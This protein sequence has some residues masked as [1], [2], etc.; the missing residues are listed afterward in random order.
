MASSILVITGHP[1][2]GTSFTASLL[3]SAGLHIGQ[4]L[5]AP[6]HGN[7]KGFFEDLD[8][9]GFHEAVLRSQGIHHVGWTVEENIPVDATFINK[10]QELVSNNAAFPIWG[11]KDPRTTLFLDFWEQLLPEANFL[12]LYRAPWEVADSIYRRGDEL[13]EEEPDLA[14][15][16]WIHYN[17]ILLQFYDKFPQKC[18]V[19]SVYNVSQH[20]AT[21]I[22]ALNQKLNLN[23]ESPADLYEQSLLQTKVSDS[24]HPGL[25]N[26]Y[27]PEAIK[28]YEQLNAR[29]K[30]NGLTP[31]QSWQ[32][33]IKAPV[34]PAWAFQD[35][36]RI[37]RLEQKVKHLQNELKKAQAEI[38]NLNNS[39]MI[40]A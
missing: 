22:Q 20:G 23:L 14:L 32:E 40:S 28:I 17:Q 35:W 12:L 2:S 39:E 37:S 8:V 6:G 21:F 33:K 18:F 19:A 38:N 30:Q 26:A 9:V 16:V 3:Q 5:M 29:E 1:R 4:K 34:E 25:I 7:I 15:K 31:D 11:W 24:H 27:F 36:I 10:A 13:F